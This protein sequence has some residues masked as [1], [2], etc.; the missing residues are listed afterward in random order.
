MGQLDAKQALQL[1]GQVRGQL[2]S[3]RGRTAARGNRCLLQG[4]LKLG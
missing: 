4:G 3:D 2:H 1:G